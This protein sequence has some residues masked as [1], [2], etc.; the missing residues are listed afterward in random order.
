MLY[1][2]G[3]CKF[4]VSIQLIKLEVLKLIGSV[5]ICVCFVSCVLIL[6]H[7]KCSNYVRGCMLRLVI[8]VLMVEM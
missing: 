1:Y 8:Y 7:W 6:D 4:E 5:V 3:L 2:D